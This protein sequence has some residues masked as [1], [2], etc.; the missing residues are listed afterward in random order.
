MGIRRGALTSDIGDTGLERYGGR[1][2]GDFLADWQFT[3]KKVK[4]VQE[5][6][7]NS[8]VVAGLRMSLEMPIRDIEWQFTGP[9]GV[10]E[11]N[12]RG[13]GI[14]NDSLEAMTHSWNDHIIDALLF[15]FYGWSMFTVTYQRDG[16]RWL[17]RKFKEL[18]QDTV[19]QWLFEDDGGLLGLRQYPH[20]WPDPIPIERMLLY[21][22]R[23]SRNNPEGESVLRP[24]WIPYFY[25]KGI[26]EIE[27]I[28]IERNL[29]GLPMIRPPMG[30]DMAEGSTD[31]DEAEKI[32]RNVRNDEQGGIVLPTP[33]GDGDHLRW[34]FELVSSGGL[35]KTIDTN[36]VV[37]RYEKRIL[38]SALSQFLM[39]GM[40][41]IG[42]LATFE[43]ATDF[44]AMLLNS[45]ADIIA[46]TFSK[47]AIPRLLRL[48]GVDPAGY[49]IRH[50]PAGDLDLPAFA[51]ILQKAGSFI[52][53]TTEDEIDLRARLRLPEK[54]PEEIDDIKSEEQARADE[55]LAMMQPNQQQGFTAFAA[56]N[57][58]EDDERRRFENTLQGR[59]KSYWRD[60]RK[61]IM[62][63]LG[64]S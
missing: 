44:H 26:Q 21:R 13:L 47:F 7:Y 16:G 40:D 34:H 60:Q 15:P 59:M 45:V 50:S 23:K 28:G 43:G 3:E 27:A 1:P 48:N 42:A 19:Y 25:T 29:A 57:A 6:L 49:G 30:A 10:D 58:P 9:E 18:G 52:T 53:W 46:E 32:V 35:S 33:L 38:M 14:L 41:N 2:R 37:S 5:M 22:F 4:R 54:S 17:W 62:E 36:M 20:I 51:D 31:R 63:G 11:D 61:R 64:A 8:P 24:A 12:D 55:R 39:L 56:G